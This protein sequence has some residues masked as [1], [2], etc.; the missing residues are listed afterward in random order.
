[1]SWWRDT[2]TGLT[3]TAVLGMTILFV[4]IVAGFELA[5]VPVWAAILRDLGLQ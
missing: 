3:V 2:W 1:M 5:G 4:L